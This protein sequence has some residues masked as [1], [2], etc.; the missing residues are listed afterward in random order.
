MSAVTQDEIINSFGISAPAGNSQINSTRTPR[1][2]MKELYVSGDSWL[3]GNV[4]TRL[5]LDKGQVTTAGGHNLV[6]D[7]TGPSI[8]CTNHTLINVAGFI[9]STFAYTV[10]SAAPVTTSGT[11]P[12][13]LVNLP[14]FVTPSTYFF[15]GSISIADATNGT[16]GASLA[17]QG[18]ATS[19]GGVATVVSPTISALSADASLSGVTAAYVAAGPDARLM[20][21]GLVGRTIRW[22]GQVA[23][24]RTTF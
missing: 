21:T 4:K 15:S 16:S 14:L 7:P 6:L 22:F 13:I 24:T 3:Y 19:V 12:V 9:A 8:D 11:G 1:C 18:R 23:V 20:V 5:S 17:I 2:S 10:L